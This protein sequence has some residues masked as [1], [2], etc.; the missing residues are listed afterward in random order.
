MV[1]EVVVDDERA[2][3]EALLDDGGVELDQGFDV[4]GH[5]R[6]WWHVRRGPG[7]HPAR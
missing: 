1:L 5:G 2:A 4:Q 7:R 3:S 6:R